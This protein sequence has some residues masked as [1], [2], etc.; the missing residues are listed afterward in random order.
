[1]Y[2]GKIVETASVDELFNNPMHPYTRALI[3]A[4][5]SPTPRDIEVE[6]PKGDVPDSINPPPGCRFYPRCIYAKDNCSVEQP[7]EEELSEN[8]FVA[9]YYPLNVIK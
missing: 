8:H 4:I 7:L 3:D 6:L 2:A 1:M 5:P 9:C